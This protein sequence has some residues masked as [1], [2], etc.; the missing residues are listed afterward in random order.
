MNVMIVSKWWFMIHKQVPSLTDSKPSSQVTFPL[1]RQ[2][3]SDFL[4]F[5]LP[6]LFLKLSPLSHPSVISR[7][8]ADSVWELS[9]SQASSDQ[10]AFSLAVQ[11]KNRL[12]FSDCLGTHLYVILVGKRKKNKKLSALSSLAESHQWKLISHIIWACDTPNPQM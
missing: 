5:S 10:F 1:C 12:V 9:S 2:Q 11:S 6:Q 7:V 3:Q 4:L 8:S